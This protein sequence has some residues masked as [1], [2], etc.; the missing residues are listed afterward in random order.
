MSLSEHSLFDKDVD[1]VKRQMLQRSSHN[2]T[3]SH[4]LG[5]S[6]L[7]GCYLKQH[8]FERTNVVGMRSA[9]HFCQSGQKFETGGFISNSFKT[10]K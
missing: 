4:I 6:N 8:H 9:D 10:E 1:S 2:K 7:N 5:G 3:W